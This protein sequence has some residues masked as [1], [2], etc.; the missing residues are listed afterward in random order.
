MRK[1]LTTADEVIDALGGTFA[2]TRLLEL[3]SHKAVSN[4]RT[5]G[6]PARTFLRLS[7]ELDT[8]GFEASPTLWGIEET[9]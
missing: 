8:R 1:T 5:R 7:E 9:P 6:L 4:W 2:V 3:S